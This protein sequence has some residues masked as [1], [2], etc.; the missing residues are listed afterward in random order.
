MEA[1]KRY[2]TVLNYENQQVYLHDYR[3][4]LFDGSVDEFVRANHGDDRVIFM[5][6]NHPPALWTK[7]LYYCNK[8]QA[9]SLINM[10]HE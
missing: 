3:P 4:D 9:Y 7:D 1:K 8:E 6:H 10:E 2:I 5:L